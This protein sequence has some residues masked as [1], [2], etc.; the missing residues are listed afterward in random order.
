MLLK[1]DR[2][3]LNN[4]SPLLFRFCIYK[5]I[6]VQ[7]FGLLCQTFHQKEPWA[8]QITSLLTNLMFYYQIMNQHLDYKPLFYEVDYNK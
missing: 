4:I 6:K 1:L 8:D 7:P 2:N 3:T 5:V